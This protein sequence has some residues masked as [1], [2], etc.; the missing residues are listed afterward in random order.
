M[1]Q[2]IGADDLGEY[3]NDIVDAVVRC[4]QRVEGIAHEDEVLRL[5]V[6]GTEE[7]FRRIEILRK[8]QLRLLAFQCPAAIGQQGSRPVMYRD[9][10]PSPQ[11]ALRRVASAERTTRLGVEADCLNQMMLRLQVGKRLEASGGLLRPLLGN[12]VLLTLCSLAS[13][14]R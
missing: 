11:D 5:D 7:V 1:P 2:L 8:D 3:R 10:Q 12:G 6:V 4:D 13:L 14:A 9:R